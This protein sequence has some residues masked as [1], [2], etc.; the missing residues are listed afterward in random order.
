M[1]QEFRVY[2]KSRPPDLMDVATA[3]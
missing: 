3:A 1:S 2:S